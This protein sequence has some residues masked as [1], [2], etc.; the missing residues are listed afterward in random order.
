MIVGDTT[1]D[2]D[3][4]VPSQ[5]VPRVEDQATDSRAQ[6]PEGERVSDAI[7]VRAG[8]LNGRGDLRDL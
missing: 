8:E 1:H 5:D 3:A 6:I 4:E 7:D 2:Q